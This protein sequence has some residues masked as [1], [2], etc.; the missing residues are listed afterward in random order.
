MMIPKD[1]NLLSRLAIMAGYGNFGKRFEKAKSQVSKQ[2]RWIADA[3]EY[4]DTTCE[5]AKELIEWG[6]KESGTYED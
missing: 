4:G 1:M 2:F 6:Q 5:P 3:I